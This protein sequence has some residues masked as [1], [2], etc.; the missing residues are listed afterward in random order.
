MKSC[1]NPGL[2]S[3]GGFDY[4]MGKGA[5]GRIEEEDWALYLFAETGFRI[6]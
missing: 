3:I 1:D 4:G 6:G 2:L 5:A